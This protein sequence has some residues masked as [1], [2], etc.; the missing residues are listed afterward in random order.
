MWVSNKHIALCCFYAFQSWQ[1]AN[2]EWLAGN[3]WPMGRLLRTPALSYIYPYPFSSP[4]P[5][6]N[7]NSN[8][9]PTLTLTLTLTL[10][11]TLIQLD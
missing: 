1:R 8:P 7:P 5:N 10:N 6:P 11:L 4:D 3:I 9:T 2:Q